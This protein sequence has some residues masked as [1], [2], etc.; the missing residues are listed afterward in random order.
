MG[1]PVVHFEV[2]GSDPVGLREFYG[3]LFGWRFQVGDA[4]TDAVSAPGEYGFVDGATTEQEGVMGI[5]GGVAGGAGY[6]SRALF[7]VGVD[8]VGEALREA[9]RLGGTVVLGPEPAE[10]EPG[11]L[12]VG[13]FVDPEGNVVGVAG[14]AAK[15]G[16]EEPE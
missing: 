6:A 16:E 13:R 8:D 2:I 15:R 14:V 11:G 4:A 3:A 10:A 7:Y 5:N 9:R 1:Q 12:V